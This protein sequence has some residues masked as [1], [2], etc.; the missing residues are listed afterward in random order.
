MKI[1]NLSFSYLDRV[2]FEDFSLSVESN[3]ITCILGESG[4]G[5]STLLDLIAG[6][7]VPTSGDIER[8]DCSYMFQSPTLFD[9][10]TVFDNLALLGANEGS[11]DRVLEEVGISHLKYAYPI[12]LSGGEKSRVSLCRVYLHDKGVW[13]LDEPFSSVDLSHKVKLLT[14]MRAK[15]LGR[16][17]LYVTHDIDE[18]L[19]IADRLIVLRDGVISHDVTIQTREDYGK[20]TL[21]S[22]IIDLMLNG[23]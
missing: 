16:C 23:D 5:K 22:S 4:V 13:L 19:Y 1:S 6:L 20:S 17:V 9:Y 18:A 21:R 7:R 3:G 11:I 8:V 15:C 10:L 14:S 2:I 12:T